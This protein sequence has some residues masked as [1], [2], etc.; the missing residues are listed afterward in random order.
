MA[1]KRSKISKTVTFN[2]KFRIEKKNEFNMFEVFLKNFFSPSACQRREER[3]DILLDENINQSKRIIYYCRKNSEW[4]LDLSAFF[5]AKKYLIRKNSLLQR[6]NFSI[7]RGLLS[8]A[9]TFRISIDYKFEKVAF[10]T[11]IIV[12]T[13]K[14]IKKFNKIIFYDFEN[15]IRLDFKK[16]DI[17]QLR[18]TNGVCEWK[19]YSY[20]SILT[21]S[22]IKINCYEHLN[23]YIDVKEYVFFDRWEEVKKELEFYAREDGQLCLN[24]VH[25]SF[26]S[27][28]RNRKNF[29]TKNEKRVH[30]LTKSFSFVNFIKKFKITATDD[31]SYLKLFN[32]WN[33]NQINKFYHD[34]S[35][36][37]GLLTKYAIANVKDL[38][39]FE[40]ICSYFS[41]MMR[42]EKKI[43]LDR[44]EKKDGLIDLINEINDEI[45]SYYIDEKRI[46]TIKNSNKKLIVND[47][48]IVE[49]VPFTKDEIKRHP[50]FYSFMKAI[51]KF[52]IKKNNQK[53]FYFSKIRLENEEE[54][55]IINLYS[56]K[57][58]NF[59]II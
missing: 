29:M 21:D 26:I 58:R 6:L 38:C 56:G 10:E 12:L 39:Q 5:L 40:I 50:L 18:K 37:C 17:L 31:N 35:I 25:H 24:L 46:K 59:K 51:L 7:N 43:N 42:N 11:R 14:R 13:Y 16:R 2:E 57:Q 54:F 4:N 28:L 48:T 1:I 23:D 44:I 30:D 9:V 27:R 32:L 47:S 19:R 55:F 49:N 53:K 45:F 52:F 41:Y 8:N 36:A 15:A 3:F 33:L 34:E 22:K 20:G